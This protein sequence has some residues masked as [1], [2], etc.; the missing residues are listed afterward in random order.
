M[1]NGASG[2]PN[3]HTE[4]S[5]VDLRGFKIA[6]TGPRKENPAG[7]IVLNR[8]LEGPRWTPRAPE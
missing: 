5:K 7:G 6:E 8:P 2:G 4:G 1:L 3:G